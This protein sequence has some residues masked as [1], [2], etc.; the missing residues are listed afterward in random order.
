M[1]VNL[2]QNMDMYL[3][4]VR[5]YGGIWTSSGVFFLL[6]VL[7]DTIIA[8]VTRRTVIVLSAYI[9]RK[10]EWW[11]KTAYRYD[12]CRGVINQYLTVDPLPGQTLTGARTQDKL[13]LHWVMGNTL[14]GYSGS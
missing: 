14:N 4:G 12:A 10:N 1:K 11:T 7:G 9:I 13:I 8:I 6:C 2:W 5:H 3:R